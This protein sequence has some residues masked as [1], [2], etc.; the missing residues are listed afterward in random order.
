M[1]GEPVVRGVAES[2]DAV[3]VLSSTTV[4]GMPGGAQDELA[5]A[6]VFAPTEKP[7]VDCATV[8]DLGPYDGPMPP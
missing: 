6:L 3:H 5:F 1:N 2:S 7:I 8:T 4:G